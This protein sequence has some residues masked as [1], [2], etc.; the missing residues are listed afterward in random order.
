MARSQST[1]PGRWFPLPLR[2]PLKQEGHT[3]PGKERCHRCRSCSGFR[4]RVPTDAR[5]FANARGDGLDGAEIVDEEVGGDGV[6][7]DHER[8]EERASMKEHTASKA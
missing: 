7:G 5:W 3:S 8:V 2:L 4:G 6:R 1:S